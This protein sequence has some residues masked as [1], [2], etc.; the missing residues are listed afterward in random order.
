MKRLIS[1]IAVAI[2]AMAMVGVSAA[3]AETVTVTPAD[4]GTSWHAADTRPPGTGTFE[5]GPATPPLG[6]GSFELQTLTNPEKVQL[7]TSNYDGVELDEIDALSYSTYRDPASTGFEAGVA[8]LNLRVDATE[9]G[10][11]D[12]YMVYEPYQD[13][14]NAAVQ[15][16]VWQS[17]DAYNGGNGK[18]W[19][20]TG[21]AGCGQATPCTWDTIVESFSSELTIQ[22]GAACGPANV[23]S[24]CPGSL[25]FNQGS[26]NSGI[27]SNVDALTVGVN[28]SSTTYDFE[29]PPPDVDEDGVPD[30]EDNCPTTS[31]EDQLDTDKDGQGNACDTDD[32]NDGVPDN[33]DACSTEA[34]KAQNGCPLPTDKDQCKNNG[35]KNYGTTFKNQGDCVSFVNKSSK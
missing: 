35:W 32:D 1:A 17:W 31:N 21:A 5:L 26:F 4:V 34:G 7:L 23:K 14:G 24:P 13:Q 22:E 19:I 2:A 8:A 9:D 12:F 3:A 27:I 11:P 33:K 30:A 18:W 15:T 25:G 29:L 20:N 10:N 6:T 28:G 16:G